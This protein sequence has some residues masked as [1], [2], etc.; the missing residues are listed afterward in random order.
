MKILSFFTSLSVGLFTVG[1]FANPDLRLVGAAAHNDDGSVTIYPY[2]TILKGTRPTK[3]W[4]LRPDFIEV[5]ENFGIHVES[6]P[7]E[8]CKKYGLQ[9]VVETRISEFVSGQNVKID[10]KGNVIENAGS[11]FSVGRITC[12]KDAGFRKVSKNTKKLKR[13]QD[14]SFTVIEPRFK[15]AG[16]NHKISYDESDLNGVCRLFGLS[17][18]APHPSTSFKISKTENVVIQSN[19]MLKGVASSNFR[20][21]KIAC[22]P[23]AHDVSSDTTP[24]TLNP[25]PEKISP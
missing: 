25:S 5:W 16:R 3:D 19:G 2:G 17:S 11:G 10:E 23:P 24:G 13:N 12:H 6:N 18:F 21:K 8:I 1:A 14:G 22:W 20:I 7:S 4:T 9:T 15:F